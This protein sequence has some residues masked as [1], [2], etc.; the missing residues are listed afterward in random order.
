[1]AMQDSRGR[2]AQDELTESS[3]YRW[4]RFEGRV[5]LVTLV[6]AVLLAV[7]FAAVSHWLQLE[8]I[9]IL[10]LI[11]LFVIAAVASVAVIVNRMRFES[12]LASDQLLPPGEK[13]E[14][15]VKLIV[16]PFFHTRLLKRLRNLAEQRI[17]AS[18]PS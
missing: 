15:K 16:V 8:S 3:L 7:T 13:S 5:A 2:T 9:A 18:R 12:A 14:L 1:M 11:S 17:A 10:G 4:A 6:T